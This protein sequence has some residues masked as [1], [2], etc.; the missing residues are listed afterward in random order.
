M[1]I[2]PILPPSVN[3]G[4]ASKVTDLEFVQRCVSG[5]KRAWD[6]FVDKYS[7]LIYNYICSI[8]RANGLNPLPQDN[9]NDAFQEIFV[10][11]TKDNF[12]KLRSFKAKNGSSFATWLR[13]VA[14][15]YTIDHLRRLK[16]LVSLDA[17]RQDGFSLKDVLADDSASAA[18]ALVGREKLDGL[19]DCIERLDSAERYFLELHL[20]RDIT[21]EELKDLFGI[22]RAAVD[23][24]KSRIVGKLKDCFKEKGFALDL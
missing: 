23:M 22:S 16:P 19:T 2:R 1:G 20:H 4:D 8:F 21:L 18:D 15:N 17:E 10:S 24:R 3:L 12:R 5:D 13:R 11:L 6:E 7:G 9:V 14:V